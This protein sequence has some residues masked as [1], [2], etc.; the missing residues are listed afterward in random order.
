VTKKHQRITIGESL[1]RKSQNP[2]C[3]GEYVNVIDWLTRARKST[4]PAM[5]FFLAGML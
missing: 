3:D 4:G 2:I 1:K 5:P